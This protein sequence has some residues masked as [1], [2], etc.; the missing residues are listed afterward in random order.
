MSRQ[1]GKR[2][3]DQRCLAVGRYPGLNLD[4]AKEHHQHDRNDHRKFGRGDAAAIVQQDKGGE[5][6]TKPHLRPRF[7]RVPL[8]RL[9][10]ERGRRDKQ[11]LV[12]G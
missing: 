10:L 4:R 8:V 2:P 5:P 7:H 12:A 9:I 1:I 11:S 6:R 3:R